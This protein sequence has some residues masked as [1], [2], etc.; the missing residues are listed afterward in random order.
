M[1]AE[2]DIN[3]A[4]TSVSVP[5]GQLPDQTGIATEVIIGGHGVTHWETSNFHHG[6]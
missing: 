4:S 5:K 3:R 2:F 1:L 6:L